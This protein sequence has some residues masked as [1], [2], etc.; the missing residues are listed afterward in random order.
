MA[1]FCMFYDAVLQEERDQLKKM[2]K[3]LQANKEQLESQE[4]KTSKDLVM[5]VSI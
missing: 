4:E 2:A 3:D 1:A 5:M